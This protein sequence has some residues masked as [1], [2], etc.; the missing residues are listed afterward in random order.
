MKIKTGED[1]I[2]DLSIGS[3]P[4]V[5]IPISTSMIGQPSSPPYSTLMEPPMNDQP[6]QYGQYPTPQQIFI[7]QPQVLGPDS[8]VMTCPHCRSRIST[9]VSTFATSKTHIIAIM[10]AFLGCFFGCC[11]IPYCT[12]SCQSQKHTCPYCRSII[13]IYG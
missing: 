13:G 1:E 12:K 6:P 11:L 3:K 5:L 4:D 8:V 9:E 10:L 7:Q 2:N